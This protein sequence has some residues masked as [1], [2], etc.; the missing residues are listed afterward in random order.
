MIKLFNRLSGQLFGCALKARSAG[1]RRNLLEAAKDPALAQE[2][3]LR[4]IL[5]AN[6]ETEFGQRHGFAKIGS[7]KD[8]RDAVPPQD[9]EDLRPLI[10]RQAKTGAPCL[11]AE[12]PVFYQRTSGTTGK[13]KDIPLTQSAIARLAGYQQIAA[14]AQ[15]AAA[16][17]FDGK[18]LAI[19]GPTLEGKRP[20]GLPYGS[21]SGLVAQQQPWFARRKYLLPEGLCSLRN[22]DQRI[23]L[24]ALLAMARN[25]VTALA[26]ANPSTL[27]RLDRVIREEAPALLDDLAFGHSPWLR[28]L[29]EGLRRE[30]E[31]RCPPNPKR[32]LALVR[33]AEK[34][35]QLGLAQLWP[36]LAALVTWTGGSCGLALAKLRERLSP[37]TRIMELGYL[38]SEV[39][40]TVVVDARRNLALPTLSDHLFEFVERDAW[41][42]GRPAF[43]GLEEL[44]L[45]GHYY[46]FVTTPEGLYRYNMNDVVTVTSRIGRTPTLAFL[47]KGRG[48]TSITGEKL[49]EAQL[50]EA[51]AFLEAPFL[52][53]LADEEAAGYRLYVETQNASAG[54][55]E[56][57]DAALCSLNIE[58]R[59]K[60]S[61]RRLALLVLVPLRPGA[62]E[63]YRRQ[64]LRE[65]QRDA[66]FKYLP[67]QYARDCRFDF[68]PWAVAA[69]LERF[70]TRLNHADEAISSKA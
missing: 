41:E 26:T 45:G 53:C 49:S 65:G 61:N 17:L 9:Y 8:Y 34:A 69:P 36:D 54:L 27:L 13:P 50:L 29:P 37:S 40:A 35:G 22:H 44:E 43:L 14:T 11:T 28:H 16:P 20:D 4:A 59:C 39:R 6:A 5:A 1:V 67:L 15:A 23:F 24:T 66:Q 64:A 68:T 46:L 25:D 60:R 7:R 57:I 2:Q 55:A 48:V 12:R 42:S 47:Q 62:G 18:I 38:A 70:P 32:T 30:I 21:A 31:R 56:R 10:D 19:G 58:Y 52:I 51:T 33:R 3:A 63:A